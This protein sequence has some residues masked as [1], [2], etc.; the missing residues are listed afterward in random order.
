MTTATHA[1]Q[2]VYSA[3]FLNIYDLWV[4]GVSNRVLWRCPTERLVAHYDQ[5]VSANHLDVGVG[6]GLLLDRCSFPTSSPRVVLC[7]L[8]ENSLAHCAQRIARYSPTTVRADVLQ[9][10][11]GELAPGSFDSVG[12]NYLL[13][14]LPGDIPGGKWAAFDSLKAALKP[15]GVLFGSTILGAGIS[16]NLAAQGVL[17]LYNSRGIFGNDADDLATLRAE[18]ERR[19]T[20]V[21]IEV[22]GLVALFTARR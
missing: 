5:H 13:H 15:E 19:F 12:L 11:P 3:S 22:V 6:T 18:L 20:R 2:A 8:N 16:P 4:H 14:C 1:G 21:H 17:K 10:L 7:D 9:P